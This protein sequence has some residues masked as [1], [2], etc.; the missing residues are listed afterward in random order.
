MRLSAERK[1]RVRMKQ[2]RGNREGKKMTGEVEQA[3]ERNTV[4]RVKKMK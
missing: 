3:R 4:A 1:Q 2:M